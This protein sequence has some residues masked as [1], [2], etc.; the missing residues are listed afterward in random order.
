MV[1]AEAFPLP[2]PLEVREVPEPVLPVED[3]LQAA[4][5]RWLLRR[6]E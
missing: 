2:L 4:E 5:A 3:R 6:E 1:G